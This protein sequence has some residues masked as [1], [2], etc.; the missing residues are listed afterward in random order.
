M[1]S[2]FRVAVAANSAI[3]LGAITGRLAP[4]TTAVLHNG[5]TIAVL[6]RSMLA[7]GS[8]GDAARRAEG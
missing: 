5:T 7:A 6:L 1:Q 2:N 8:F 3:L 4:L